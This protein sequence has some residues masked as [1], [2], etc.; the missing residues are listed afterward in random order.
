MSVDII[1]LPKAKP[2]TGTR[3][4]RQIAAVRK[5]MAEAQVISR[6]SYSWEK[7]ER[8][9]TW[10]D[11]RGWVRVKGISIET[12]DVH[13]TPGANATKAEHTDVVDRILTSM[14]EAGWEI[15]AQQLNEYGQD[16]VRYQIHGPG[17]EEY[18][19]KEIEERRLKA[20]ESSRREQRLKSET[21]EI[22]SILAGVGITGYVSISAHYGGEAR[23]RLSLEHLRK[24]TGVDS[25]ATS[26]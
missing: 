19:E 16:V 20:E 6:G 13:F 7:D 8:L 21:A 1:E 15:A 26:E 9:P 4:T 17:V 25:V 24:L 11:Q 5:R 2:Y 12:V 3:Q 22:K 18:V 10:H 23:V 14:R